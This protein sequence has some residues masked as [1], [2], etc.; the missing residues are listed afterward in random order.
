MKLTPHTPYV[1]GAFVVWWLAGAF[2]FQ[3]CN[4]ANTALVVAS[5]AAWFTWRVGTDKAKSHE[6]ALEDPPARLY[7]VSDFDV[8]ASIKEVMQNNIGDKWWVQK[9]FD[10]TQDEE[11]NM[12]AKYLMTY[13][14]EF[15]TPQPAM[16]K[17]QLILD[18][19]VS[20]V[21]SQTSV[22]LNYQVASD[23]MRFVANEVLENTTA[24]IWTRLDRLVAAKGASAS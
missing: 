23:K 14:E 1:I 22:K 20:K 13:E 5:L 15:K 17:R 3:L 12:K 11:G 9:S 16:L 10:D 21:A 24:M 19:K 6:S 4:N 2:A 7:N 8:F 18:I